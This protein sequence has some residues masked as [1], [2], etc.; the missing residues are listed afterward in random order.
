MDLIKRID[1]IKRTICIIEGE[2][3]FMKNDID[4]LQARYEELWEQ[5][6][7]LQAEADRLEDE[8]HRQR[9]AEMM[10]GVTVECEQKYV[11]DVEER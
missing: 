4:K 5:Q 10:R 6:C 8:L 11:P 7:T 1:H 3:L 9:V 2:R